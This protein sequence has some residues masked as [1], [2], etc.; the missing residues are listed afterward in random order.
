MN[1]TA[2]REKKS[3]TIGLGVRNLNLKGDKMPLPATLLL[4]T[5]GFKAQKERNV[6]K[7]QIGYIKDSERRLSL[8]RPTLGPN[9]AMLHPLYLLNS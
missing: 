9:V 8:Q 5:R 3:G 7:N 2:R 1:E 6:N 4:E